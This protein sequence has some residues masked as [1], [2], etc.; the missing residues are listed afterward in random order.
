MTYDEWKKAR[1]ITGADIRR[2]DEGDWDVEVK[3]I[4]DVEIALLYG[5]EFEV[6]YGKY[7]A[8]VTIFGSCFCVFSTYH[9][10]REKYFEF[11]TDDLDQFAQNA[12]VGPHFIKDVVGKWVITWHV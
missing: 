12:T 3:T 8:L 4:R 6:S 10:K 2:L 9:G 5:R 11:E 1:N 7:T